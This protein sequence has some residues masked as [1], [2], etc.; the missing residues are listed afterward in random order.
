MTQIQFSSWNLAIWGGGSWQTTIMGFRHPYTTSPAPNP[1]PTPFGAAFY[2]KYFRKGCLNFRCQLDYFLFSYG[3]YRW[4][5][6]SRLKLIFK[7]GLFLV[8]LLLLFQFSWILSVNVTSFMFS[9]QVQGTYMRYSVRVKLRFI[10]IW[11]VWMIK[12]DY[13]NLRSAFTI[14]IYSLVWQALVIIMAVVIYCSICRY[15]LRTFI[16]YFE[17]HINK[18]VLIPYKRM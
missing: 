16:R 13:N 10:Y 2:V 5:S 8:Y 4:G 9:L 6:L 7:V 1:L 15:F 17:E 18:F 14:I 12:Y 3:R 11:W